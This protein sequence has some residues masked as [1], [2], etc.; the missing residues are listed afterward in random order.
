MNTL[1]QLPVYDY[2]MY[3]SYVQQFGHY[4][5]INQYNW[6]VHMYNMYNIYKSTHT[7]TEKLKMTFCIYGMACKNTKCKDFHH[8]S[9]DLQI[10]TESRRKSNV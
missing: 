10:L 4:P 2:N 1:S 3:I 8:P 7:V 5:N 9:K 6:F